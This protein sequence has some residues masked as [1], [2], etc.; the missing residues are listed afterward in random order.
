MKEFLSNLAALIKVKTVVTF[1]VT[2]IFC[3]LALRGT[4]SP[5]NVM[6]VVT[7]VIGFYFGTQKVKEGEE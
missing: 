4:I 7:M 6:T 2:A 3:V 1:S 5:E